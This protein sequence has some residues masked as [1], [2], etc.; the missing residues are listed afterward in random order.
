MVVLSCN[1]PKGS[2]KCVKD[3]VF[4]ELILSFNTSQDVTGKSRRRQKKIINYEYF[5]RTMVLVAT[6][7]K[8]KRGPEDGKEKYEKRKKEEK[9]GWERK[10][11]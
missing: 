8:G 11:R 5:E 3:S 10:K 4:Q 2:T 1:R 9:D 6:T 7:K